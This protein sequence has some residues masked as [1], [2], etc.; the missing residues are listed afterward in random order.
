MKENSNFEQLLPNLVKNISDNYNTS[1]VLLGR[2]TKPLPARRVIIDAV[3]ELQSILFPVYIRLSRNRLHQR[4]PTKPSRM[5]LR[6]ILPSLRRQKKSVAGFLQPFQRFRSSYYLMQR[7][8]MT[9]TLP[10]LTKNRLFSPIPDFTQPLYTGQ[11]MNY[12]KN[13]FRL[14]QES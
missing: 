11:R 9:V 7:P 12:T 5:S 6:P 4:L 10:H 2:T 3:N 13:M 1:D 14:F 8:V